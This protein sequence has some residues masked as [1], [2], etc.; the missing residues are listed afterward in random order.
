MTATVDLGALTR[1]L[2]DLEKLDPKM[3]HAF[4]VLITSALQDLQAEASPKRGRRGWLLERLQAVHACPRQN[5]PGF[6]QLP[7]SAS[8]TREWR[9]EGCGAIVSLDG[10]TSSTKRRKGGAK[11]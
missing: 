3:I 11:P 2:A 10:N 4:D 5:D 1:K 9:C 6:V 8:G 7:P